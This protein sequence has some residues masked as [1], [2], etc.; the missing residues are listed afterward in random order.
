VTIISKTASTEYIAGG[1]MNRIWR[2]VKEYQMKAR[3]KRGV[4]PRCGGKYKPQQHGAFMHY[5][6]PKCGWLKI[7]Y[8]G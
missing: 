2:K 1:A 7:D 6:C 5:F 4:C 3:D 8:I